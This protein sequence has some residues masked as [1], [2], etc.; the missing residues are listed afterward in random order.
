L[1]YIIANI[2]L[3]I[4]APISFCEKNFNKNIDKNHH[5][6]KTLTLTNFPLN[7]K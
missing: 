6:L 4:Q 5:V 2:W 1:A 3:E 7:I